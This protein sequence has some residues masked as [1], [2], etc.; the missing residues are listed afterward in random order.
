MLCVSTFQ[1]DLKGVDEDPSRQSTSST[2]STCLANPRMVSRV[3]EFT[4]RTS[5]SIASLGQSINFTS[6]PETA[7]S[8]REASS[9]RLDFVRRSLE[10]RGICPEAVD[11]VC[12]SWT[13]GT[14]K[15]YRAVWSKWM[16]WCN[17]RN[18]NPLQASS[19][20][21]TNFLAACFNE[22]K[23]YSTLNTYRSALSSTL[24]PCDNVT[25]VSHP[26]VCRLLK[27]IFH[28]RPPQPRYSVTWDV[29]TL[30]EYLKT[31][32]PLEELNL[33]ML[34]LKTVTLCALVSAQR[35]QTLA[36]L[37]IDTMNIHEDE[38]QFVVCAR[39]K[40]SRFLLLMIMLMFALRGAY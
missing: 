16:G 34:T 22:G 10:S 29:S 4:N 1:F 20:E 7:P 9:G 2:D 8:S 17:Q 11:I 28:L 25:V 15:Q 21:V 26:L 14:E 24:C 36:A 30:T 27:G 31:L 12:A 39:L 18:S 37:D 23:S 38:I 19:V 40:M 3:A 13:S 35:C 33:K 6:Q 32:F 5:N